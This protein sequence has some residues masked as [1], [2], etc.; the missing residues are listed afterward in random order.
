MPVTLIG[1][2]LPHTLIAD[3]IAEADVPDMHSMR[4]VVSTIID[5]STGDRRGT[6]TRRLIT[7]S[8]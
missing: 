3:S 4:H 1:V 8:G 7:G 2:L 6:V 5:I